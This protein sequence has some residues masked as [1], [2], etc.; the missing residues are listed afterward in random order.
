MKRASSTGSGLLIGILIAVTAIGMTAFLPVLPCGFCRGSIFGARM[1]MAETPGITPEHAAAI[2]AFALADECN[3]CRRGR[4]TIL[5]YVLEE[6][7]FGP[8]RSQR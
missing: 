3:N 6:A 5:K 8:L 7:P 1:R 4:I 2:R